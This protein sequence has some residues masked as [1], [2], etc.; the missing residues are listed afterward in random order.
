M[1]QRN[2]S[3]ATSPNAGISQFCESCCHPAAQQPTARVNQ[4]RGR[5]SPQKNSRD[6]FSTLH[7]RLGPEGRQSPVH[8]CDGWRTRRLHVLT[9]TDA[10]QHTQCR[11]GVN[12]QQ[13]LS[14]NH[15]FIT[16][17]QA[18]S[19]FPPTSVAWGSQC[20]RERGSLAMKQLVPP[21][22]CTPE[23]RSGSGWE[24]TAH[25]QCPPCDPFHHPPTLCSELIS[26]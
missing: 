18:D 12:L 7:T 26:Q 5:E 17:S 3:L 14:E 23:S 11:Q 20:R 16:S 1:G 4:G 25:H 9:S 6:R 22:S 15:P 2:N 21:F 13:L 8:S 24:I 10:L 19:T